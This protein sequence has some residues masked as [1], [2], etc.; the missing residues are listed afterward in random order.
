MRIPRA[1]TVLPGLGLALAL[2]AGPASPAGAQLPAAGP[3]AL[4]TAVNDGALARGYRA[5]AR[6]PADL[7]LPGNPGFSITLAPAWAALGMGP[8]SL[9]DLADYENREVPESRRR[10]WLRRIADAGSQTGST[11]A[12]VTAL[13]F[14]VRRFAFQ[15]ASVGNL[16]LD[17]NP[18]TAELLLFGNAGL[19]GTPRD[20]VLGDSRADGFAATTFAAS[21]GLPLQLRLGPPGSVFAAGVT[22]KYTVGHALLLGRNRGSRVTADPLALDLAFPI[23]TRDSD[24]DGM[25]AGSGFG[26]DLGAAWQ[27]ERLTL[28]A[29]LRNVIQT[30]SW[31]ASRLT[32]RPGEAFFNGGTSSSDF[33][34]RP[35]S[36]APAFLRREV[37]DRTFKPGLTASAAWRVDPR[38]SLAAELRHEFGDGLRPAE[39]TH[40]GAGAE[41]RPAALLA[42]RGG[43]AA[44]TGGI[45]FA[46]GGGVNLGGFGIDAGVLARTGDV[47]LTAAAVG[48][49]YRSR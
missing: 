5:V 31:D 4:G 18:D 44:V 36:E 41:Y 28:G 11:G 14:S 10:E 8:V 33:E 38:L 34:E 27:G 35:L 3:T 29:S 7:G 48:L 9:G 1:R 19:T 12:E 46:A 6:N 17:I 30:F 37:E 32:Y 25:N 24:W 40:L 47:D 49:S 43:V 39:R 45:Q 42:L 16:D 15:V 21:F 26:L 22:A 2:A 13:A 23:V 20:Y